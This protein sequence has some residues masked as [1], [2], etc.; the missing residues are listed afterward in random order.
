MAN[1]YC[2]TEVA[3]CQNSKTE[4]LV[5]SSTPGTPY[6]KALQTHRVQEESHKKVL[7]DISCQQEK[8]IW[9]PRDQAQLAQLALHI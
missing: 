1:R 8:Q 2:S 6:H 3:T 5:I 4:G 9:S 7:L